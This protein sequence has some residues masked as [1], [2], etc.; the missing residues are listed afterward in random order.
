[1]APGFE[2]DRLGGG[3]SLDLA[4]YSGHPVVLNFWA[5]WCGPCEDEAGIL[6]QAW[7]RWSKR[8]IV[9]I[10]VDLRDSTDAAESYIERWGI[11]YPI[12]VDAEGDTADDYGLSGL[13]QTVVVSGDGRIV[14]RTIGPVTEAKIDSVLQDVSDGT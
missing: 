5:S 9:F 4:K 14:N 13:P 11:T 1:V 6:E 7:R 8:G 2:L 12:A 10:G 3:A